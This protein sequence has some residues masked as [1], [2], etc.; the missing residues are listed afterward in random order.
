MPN[1]HRLPYAALGGYLAVILW[2][3]LALAQGDAPEN[4]PKLATAIEKGQGMPEKA[5]SPES[6]AAEKPS[7]Q[8]TPAAKP[9]PAAP[10]EKKRPAKPACDARC[11]AAEKREK[12]DLKA[13]QS[14]AT[15]AYD[16]VFL[17][18]WQI[19]LGIAGIS[20]LVGTLIYTRR[21]AAEAG[22]AAK[23]GID[24][25]AAMRRSERAYVTMSHKRPG[26]D[27]NAELGYAGFTIEIK[28]HGRTPATVKDVLLQLDWFGVA[29]PAPDQPAYRTDSPRKEVG[30]FLV[31]QAHF[32][33]AE[34]LPL[35][36][37][38]NGDELWLYGYVDYSDEF[39][40]EYRSGYARVYNDARA[41]RHDEKNNLVFVDKSGWN[42]D[43][44]RFPD[45]GDKSK[46]NESD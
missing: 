22:R 39:G 36:S 3:N 30:F 2:A 34:S 26:L 8:K 5:L 16:L 38:G 44:L 10:I 17:T 25:V 6:K 29:N 23:A 20:L 28:N 19:G 11:Q 12:D 45:E 21:A 33:H 7:G 9:P 31:A 13:Q 40:Q 27:L 4:I 37:D 42:Y 15:S 18:W 41:G 43:R 46:N 35:P 24:A 1:R 14:M 32:F